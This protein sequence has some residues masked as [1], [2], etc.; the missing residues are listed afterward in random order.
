LNYFSGGKVTIL[1]CE[2]PRKSLRRIARGSDVV[3]YKV[4]NKTTA[5]TNIV[6]KRLNYK[7]TAGVF[8]RG[9]S[10]TVLVIVCD[11]KYD[12]VAALQEARQAF[13]SDNVILAKDYMTIQ[14]PDKTTKEYAQEISREVPSTLSISDSEDEKSS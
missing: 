12:G 8:A 4:F 11:H 13:R 2:N 1:S 7:E 6:S 10:A 3:I 9:A 5:G 14:L